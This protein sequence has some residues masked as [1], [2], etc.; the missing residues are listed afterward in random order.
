MYRIVYIVPMKY[1]GR[2]HHRKIRQNTFKEV[3]LLQL[4]VCSIDTPGQFVVVEIRKYK[5]YNNFSFFIPP[6]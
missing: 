3:A 6:S 5:S 1:G 4:F 2:Y